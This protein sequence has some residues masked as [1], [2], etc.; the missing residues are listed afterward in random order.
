MAPIH[1]R[2]DAHEYVL[3]PGTNRVD[4][5]TMTSSSRQP[6]S[7]VPDAL[8]S[9]PRLQ[10]H[11]IQLAQCPVDRARNDHATHFLLPERSDRQSN[12]LD[13]PSPILDPTTLD[14]IVYFQR[15]H[16]ELGLLRSRL[17][18]C[19]LSLCPPGSSRLGIHKLL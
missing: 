11:A 18:H 6:A 17:S 9:P 15:E 14:R 16:V 10:Y 7:N 5:D 1:S 19:R 2:D 8:P 3:Y 13:S 4:T 12:Y